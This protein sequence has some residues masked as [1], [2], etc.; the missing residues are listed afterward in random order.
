MNRKNT[1]PRLWQYIAECARLLYWA[2]FKPYTLDRWLKEIHPELDRASNPFTLRAEFPS[3][4]RLYRYAMQF[5]WLS[6]M[7]PLLAVPP[8]GQ[9]YSLAA[10]EPFDWPRSTLFLLGWFAGLLLV[11]FNSRVLNNWLALAILV[12]NGLL[13]LLAIG[14]YLVSVLKISFLQDILGDMLS[15]PLYIF[16]VAVAF[17]MVFEALELTILVCAIWGIILILFMGHKTDNSD[18]S[19]WFVFLNVIN[20][21]RASITLNL[22]NNLELENSNKTN[23]VFFNAIVVV[24]LAIL[25]GLLEAIKTYLELLF[26][27][28]MS[29]IPAT[30]RVLLWLVYLLITIAIIQLSRFISSSSLLRYLPPYFDELIRLPLPF[31]DRLI[32]N[33]YRE[34]RVAARQTID[35]LIAS[36]NQQGAAARAMTL[37]AVDSLSSCQ[38]LGDIVFIAE[39]LAWFPSPPPAELGPILPQFLEISQSVRSAADATSAYRKIELLNSPIAALSNLRNSLAFSKNAELA[40]RLGNIAQRW[41]GILETARTLEEE[42]RY[43]REISQVYISGPSLDPETAKNRF[44]GRQD[45]FREIETVALSPQPPVLLLYGGRRSGKTSALKYLPE[46][47]GGELVPLLVDM[48]GGATATTLRSLARYLAEQIIEA[49]LKSR[50]LQLPYP[51]KRDLAED[52]FPALQRWLQQVERRAPG[53]RFLLCLDEFER[54]SEV[55]RE[56]GSR[57]P[58]N[59]L[60]HVMQHR[61]QWILLFSGSHTLDELD[62]YWSDYLINTRSLRLTYLREEEARE[63]IVA[64]VEDFPDIYQPE[65]VARIVELS[66]CQPFLVQLLCYALVEELNRKAAGADPRATKATAADVEAIVPKA[67]ETGGMYFRELWRGT[68]GPQERQA[69]AR[70]LRGEPAT[71]E[72]SSAWRKLEQKEVLEIEATGVS[73]AP[74]TEARSFQVPLVQRYI[75]DFAIKEM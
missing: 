26:S 66:R 11:H 50:N 24:F 65:A 38:T 75:E 18:F 60:R 32:A 57:S 3:N 12:A 36:T 31:M 1:A 25:W 9:I 49:A 56:T 17:G 8:L 46:K 39:Q 14:S 23:A 51:D 69:I 13:L 70:L 64:P 34:N 27:A 52:P 43:S 30:F 68:L 67:L 55:V 53:K 58:L 63:L 71:P 20:G 33:A 2:Y 61:Q 7:V 62:D 29:M 48:Q 40:A 28:F 54:L 6:A 37:I 73:E 5:W 10:S 59:F 42:S 4:P 35:Y 47:V 19:L 21:I 41:Q 44:K 45:I 16:S 72:D 22:I 15:Y 74:P